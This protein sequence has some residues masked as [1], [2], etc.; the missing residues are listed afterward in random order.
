MGPLTAQLAALGMPPFKA[1][2]TLAA[3]PEGYV[4]P[5]ARLHRRRDIVLGR[6]VFLDERVVVYQDWYGAGPV[7]L[8]D[9]V[10]LMRDT[11][12][13]VGEG[14]GVAIGEETHI[15]SGC[16]LTSYAGPLRIGRRCHIAPNCGFYTYDYDLGPG[17]LVDQPHVS[18][19]G[20]VVEDDVWIGFGVTVL[21]G[22]RVG[23]D[24]V[25]A[26]GA[27][28]RA[29]V[30]AGAI[31]AGVPARIV[32]WRAGAGPATSPTTSMESIPAS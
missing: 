1:R 18:A 8:D 20:I 11:I 13:E 12:I 6:H 3:F 21:D 24:A 16:R 4:A 10:H 31:V 14:G 5:S 26:A 22:V 23:R 7:V 25:L 30:P 17:R 9:H 27:V 2:I 15:Q 32:G 28:V 29:D 19:G